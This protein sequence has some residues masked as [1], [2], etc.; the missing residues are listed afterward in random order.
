VDI[1]GSGWAIS[2][3][4][5]NKDAAW[6]VLNAILKAFFQ[7]PPP[8]HQQYFLTVNKD[9]VPTE[10][11]ERWSEALNLISKALGPVWEGKEDVQ[12]ALDKVAPAVQK[13]LDEVQAERAKR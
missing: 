6:E 11:F 7:P 2:S 3:Q 8:R 1:D 10:T 9:A 5:R 4:S 13:I 12:T